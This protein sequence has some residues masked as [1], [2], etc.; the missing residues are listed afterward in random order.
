MVLQRN[1]L[2]QLKP[3]GVVERTELIQARIAQNRAIRETAATAAILAAK[4]RLTVQNVISSKSRVLDEKQPEA[5][6]AA[7]A[8]SS[9]L[10][11]RQL[12]S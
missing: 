2:D 5:V 6:V 8:R 3:F 1:E 9:L 11:G 4:L 7:A 12:D 10:S